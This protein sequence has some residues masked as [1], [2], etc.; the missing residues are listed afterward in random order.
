M[1]GLAVTATHTQVDGW[2]A[3]AGADEAARSAASTAGRLV[4][5]GDLPTLS[6]QL[7]PAGRG[8]TTAASPSLT[9]H[10]SAFAA[11]AGAGPVPAVSSSI[12]LEMGH[13]I[14]ARPAADAPVE[15]VIAWY[16]AKGRLHE[17]IAEAGGPD[18]AAER[19]YA[20]AAY[21][22]ARR[23]WAGPLAEVLS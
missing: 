1:G 4:L 3:A 10:G 18:A 11:T 14:R 7:R 20:A 9:D 23:L 13:L 15:Q 17:H 12:L 21:E 19:R 6:G 16:E 22:H 8:T 2:S 5:H